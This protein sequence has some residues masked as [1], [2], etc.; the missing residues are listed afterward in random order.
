MELVRMEHGHP[1]HQLRVEPIAF[2]VLVG[3]NRR[4]ANCSGSTLI[5]L[6]PGHGIQ[7]AR[8]S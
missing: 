3:K 8:G 4:S 7:V 2:D 6:A 1:G 5:N